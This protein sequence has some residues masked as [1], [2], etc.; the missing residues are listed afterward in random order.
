MKHIPVKKLNQLIDSLLIEVS[1]VQYLKEYEKRENDLIKAF[2][3]S[4]ERYF[5]KQRIELLKLF[6]KQIRPLLEATV[7]S[8][9]LP[10]WDEV[11]ETTKTIIS[12]PLEDAGETIYKE[13][14]RSLLDFLGF[15]GT[16]PISFDIINRRAIN[17]FNPDKL[18]SQISDTTQGQ[19]RNLVNEAVEQGLSYT[20]LS[21]N[22]T[23]LFDEFN[24]KKDVNGRTRADR[25][26]INEI[27]ERNSA[28]SE[29]VAD[30]LTK[31]GFDVEKRWLTRGDSKVRPSHNENE[32]QGYIPENKKFS[33]GDD[34]PPTDPNCRC[35]NIRRIKQ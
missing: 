7:R 25:I 24:T 28:A 13:E 30:E 22:I 12:E 18:I 35:V 23:N 34:R 17:F 27:R 33:S 32:E 15:D 9:W 21:K 20:Q 19:I 2:L 6:N 8:E 10:L 29:I 1:Q 16:T 5:T 26:A 11:V 31:K 3:P 4:V 14:Y